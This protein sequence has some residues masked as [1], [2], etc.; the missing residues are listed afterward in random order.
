[1]KASDFK[2]AKVQFVTLDKKRP[3][4]FDYNALCVVQE[5][6]PDP[7]QAIDAM[8]D[9]DFSAIRVL[10]H[11]CLHAGAMAKEQECE[12]TLAQVGNMLGHIMFK[13]KKTFDDLFKAVLDSVKD[14]LPENSFVPVEEVEKEKKEVEAKN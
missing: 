11:A 4:S 14:F 6:Y 7:F 13:E 2:K 10:V 3:V 8:Q 12:F 1:M 5:S 9:M